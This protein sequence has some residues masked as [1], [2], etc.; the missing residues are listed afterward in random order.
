MR[1][2]KSDLVKMTEKSEEKSDVQVKDESCE[3]CGSGHAGSSQNPD[4]ASSRAVLCRFAVPDIL[5]HE[6]LVTGNGSCQFIIRPG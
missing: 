3:L 2:E 1:T 4:L 6:R 5:T